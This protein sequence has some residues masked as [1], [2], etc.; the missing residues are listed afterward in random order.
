[1]HWRR[2]LYS[3]AFILLTSAIVWGTSSCW[4]LRGQSSWQMWLVQIVLSGGLVWVSAA[5][6]LVLDR[7]SA[8]G[9]GVLGFLFSVR[10]AK[11]SLS[12]LCAFLL[13]LTLS[14]SVQDAR[15]ERGVLLP[16]A[17]LWLVLWDAMR[18]HARTR[19]VISAAHTDVY[20]TITAVTTATT[21]SAVRALLAE[22]ARVAVLAVAMCTTVIVVTALTG[23]A[24]GKAGA[25]IGAAWPGLGAAVLAVVAGDAALA[26]TVWLAASTAVVVSVAL[27][28]LT[29]AWLTPI[30]FSSLNHNENDHHR[31]L[32]TRTNEN[33]LISALRLADLVWDPRSSSSS[34][35]INTININNNRS[36]SSNIIIN[37]KYNTNKAESKYAARYKQLLSQ[38]VKRTDDTL[39]ALQSSVIVV[40][41]FPLSS[42]FGLTVTDCVGSLPAMGGVDALNVHAYFGLLYRS[43]AFFDL[44]RLVRTN[45]ARRQEIIT[46]RWDEVLDSI[47]ILLVEYSA[48]VS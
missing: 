35:D 9:L 15:E 32:A 44:N 21:T 14:L 36:S 48:Q 37:N 41:G 6:G 46:N 13:T 27:Q 43:L 18:R 5:A 23:I 3:F 7:A 1:V 30:D 20:T 40:A 12:L 39:Q 29:A 31:D 25:L 8:G 38:Y 26:Q 4:I 17:A 10:T 2:S 22:A 11:L 28:S 47:L 16:V 24:T 42:C 19:H 33:V 45:V 34:S